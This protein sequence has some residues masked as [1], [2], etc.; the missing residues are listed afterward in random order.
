MVGRSLCLNV[1]YDVRMLKRQRLQLLSDFQPFLDGQGSYYAPRVKVRALSAAVHRHHQRDDRQIRRRHRPVG[2]EGLARGARGQP[3]WWVA[4]AECYCAR[5]RLGSLERLRARPSQT[6]PH[7]H[8][9]VRH[10]LT[11]VNM[12]VLTID[13]CISCTEG[14][15]GP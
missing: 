3:T 12:I 9:A 8:G 15:G 14:T 5:Q 4:A 7:G 10:D 6:S 1:N 2:V 13:P 11:D